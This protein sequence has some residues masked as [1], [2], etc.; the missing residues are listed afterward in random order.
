MKLS[1]GAVF[2]GVMVLGSLAGCGGGGTAAAPAAA[3]TTGCSGAVGSFFAAN[4]KTATASITTYNATPNATPTVLGVFANG[5][6]ASV[7]VKSDCTITVG[8]YTLKATDGTYTFANNQSDVDMTGTGIANGHFEKFAN[9]TSMLGFKDP[10]S[11]DAVQFNL[12]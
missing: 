7:T 2:I 3:A 9:G 5:A 8:S 1:R 11:S 10:A 4:A 6:S 12:P